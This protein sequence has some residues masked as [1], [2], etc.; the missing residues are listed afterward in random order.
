M[1]A[2]FRLSLV[3]PAS[4]GGTTPYLVGRGWH[5]SDISQLPPCCMSPGNARHCR[6][7]VR[8][9]EQHLNVSAPLR[10]APHAAS[11]G[12]VVHS[13]WLES[14]PAC[15]AGASSTPAVW[16]RHAELLP[17]LGCAA[18]LPLAPAGFDPWILCVSATTHVKSAVP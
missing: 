3:A 6:F 15:L 4:A 14:L 1:A 2:T 9:F 10:R 12:C 11:A 16:L 18:L 8:S 7:L 13:N 17:L 5:L